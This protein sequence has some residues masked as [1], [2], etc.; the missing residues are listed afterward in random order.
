[1][2]K[3]INFQFTLISDLFTTEEG[4]NFQFSMIMDLFIPHMRG[5]SG[6]F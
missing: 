1:M 3:D 5:G 2:K 6:N 4:I